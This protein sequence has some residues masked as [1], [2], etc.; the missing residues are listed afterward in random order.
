MC[1]TFSRVL[2]K[3]RAI[4]FHARMFEHVL[5]FNE[6]RSERLLLHRPGLGRRPPQA[7]KVLRG[8]HDDHYEDDTGL[9]QL[10]NHLA[11]WSVGLRTFGLADLAL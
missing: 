6:D 11:C 9:K 7:G 5:Q 10:L 8:G 2:L 3:Y 1:H 4:L